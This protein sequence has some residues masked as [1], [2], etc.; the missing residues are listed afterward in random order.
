ME[1]SLGL[2]IRKNGDEFEFGFVDV[3]WMPG[4]STLGSRRR[5]QFLE[6]ASLVVGPTRAR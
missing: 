3:L 2:A 6:A 5:H 1:G 4:Q